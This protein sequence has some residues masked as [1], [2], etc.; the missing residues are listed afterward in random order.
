MDVR[1]GLRNV[2]PW[3]HLLL[4][5]IFFLPA[6][7]LAVDLELHLSY[8]HDNPPSQGAERFARLAEQYARGGLHI[9]VRYEPKIEDASA[10]LSRVERGEVA[11]ADTLMG[12]AE[13][14]DGVW[15]LSSLPLL[16]R[17]YA[18]AQSFYR[19][20]RPL[21]DQ[22]AARMGQH[23][24]Y[25]APWPPSG[26]F[27]N[28]PLDSLKDLQG[29]R[30]RTYDSIG[31]MF[32]QL[33]GTDSIALPWLQVDTWIRRGELDAVLTSAVSGVEARFVDRFRYFYRLHYAIPLNM[34]TIDRA[35]WASL[36]TAQQE[37]IRRAAAQVENEQWQ[38]SELRNHQALERLRQGGIQLMML[39]DRLSATLQRLAGAFDK[40]T[41]AVAVPSAVELLRLYRPKTARAI[42]DVAALPEPLQA[43]KASLQNTLN[44]MERAA[45][46]TAAKLSQT[47]LQGKQARAE[48]DSLCTQFAFAVDCAA[49]DEAGIM[50]TVVPETFHHYEGSDISAQTHFRRLHATR[51]SVLSDTFRSKEGILAVA[52]AYPVIMGDG[53]LLGSVSLLLDPA[54]MVGNTVD[55]A[56]GKSPPEIWTIST[57]GRILYAPDRGKT[58]RDLFSDPIFNVFPQ[59][60]DIGAT[61][62]EIPQGE[63]VYVALGDGLT[64]PVL[65]YV[66][67][68]TV[69]LSGTTWHIAVSAAKTAVDD[70]AEE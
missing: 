6:A 9:N 70:Q 5:L 12:L 60:R 39:D 38:N 15:A 2:T 16:V 43:L 13:E 59:L 20:A 56:V 30:V 44:A 27:T 65:K 54:R 14:R 18:Q 57:E 22:A 53:K 8:P 32:F 19:A 61:M 47:G 36:G 29:L 51:R 62:T 41:G 31:A 52:F 49:I 45:A 68:T 46:D 26:L 17:S 11:M 42:A 50:V 25:T 7:T 4:C 55:A 67:W 64:I 40:A 69:G 3:L 34:L 37:A 66:D 28:A 1:H 35:V 58:G 63:D 24:L 21:Y 23:L 33:I 10:L 48:L